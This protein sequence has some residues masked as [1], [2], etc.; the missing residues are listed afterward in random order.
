MPDDN[1][2]GMT[3]EK[4]KVIPQERKLRKD[5]TLHKDQYGNVVIKKK[6]KVILCARSLDIQIR[7]KQ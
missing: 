7:V 1:D 2:N 6:G 3:I 5:C 4:V